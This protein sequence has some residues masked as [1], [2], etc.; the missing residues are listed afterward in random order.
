LGIPKM[1]ATVTVEVHPADPSGPVHAWFTPHAVGVPYDKQPSLPRAHVARLPLTHFVCPAVQ[2]FVQ[3]DPL[4]HAP[5]GHAAV[6]PSN[7]QFCPSA[8]Q[9]VIVVGFTQAVVPALVQTGSVLQVHAADPELPVQLWC[10]PHNCG[11]PYE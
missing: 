10:G 2:L 7:T 1:L 5:L 3:H 9:L 6:G 11:A 8:R 4:L